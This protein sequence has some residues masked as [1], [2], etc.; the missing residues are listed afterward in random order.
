MYTWRTNLNPLFFPNVGYDLSNDWTRSLSVK[1]VQFHEVP[2]VDKRKR[3][4]LK[5]MK[6]LW[7]RKLFA[8][9]WFSWFRKMSHSLLPRKPTPFYLFS[10][11]RGY[12]VKPYRVDAKR[13]NPTK[14]RIGHRIRKGL[15]RWGSW[16]SGLSRTCKQTLK[17]ILKL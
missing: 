2:L 9:S 12:F 13:E 1:S 3:S 8:D 17:H 11:W 14:K 5:T 15:Y 7:S 6:S 16:R 4:F 10:C